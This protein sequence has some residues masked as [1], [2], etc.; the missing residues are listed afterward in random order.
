MAPDVAPTYCD[1]LSPDSRVRDGH[2]PL[3]AL[4]E[5]IRRDP[6]LA[7]HVF[8]YRVTWDAEANGVSGLEAFGDLVYRQLWA[9]LDQETAAFAAQPAP[10]WPSRTLTRR[11]IPGSPYCVFPRRLAQAERGSP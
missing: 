2:A 4:K 7:P 3:H 1:A 10:G 11:P 5:R 9:A 6:D 8:D